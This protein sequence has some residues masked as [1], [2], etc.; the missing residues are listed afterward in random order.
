LACSKGHELPN[1]EASQSDY[2]ACL[3]AAGDEAECI[4]H[5]PML[6]CYNSTAPK[7]YQTLSEWHYQMSA[8]KAKKIVILVV[9]L[10]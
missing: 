2:C 3:S 1:H 6:K 8:R 10:P 9:C 5:M 7:W 4:P